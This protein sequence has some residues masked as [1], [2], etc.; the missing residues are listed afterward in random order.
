MRRMSDIHEAVLSL[1]S[2]LRRRRL[3]LVSAESCTGGWIAKTEV[4]TPVMG[5]PPLPGLVLF[6]RVSRVSLFGASGGG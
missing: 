1:A 5:A 2:E 4:C 6:D 3:R